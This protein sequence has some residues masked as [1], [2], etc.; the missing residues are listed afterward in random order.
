MASLVYNSWGLTHQARQFSAL[1]ISYG[2][3]TH[4]KTWL[5]TSSHLPL[6][7]D[8]E[9]HWSYNIGKKMDAQVQTTQTDIA[10]YFH[11]EL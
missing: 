2:V 5:E 11:V 4:E 1:A 10:H 7:Y 8:P 3:Y 9:S 6:I